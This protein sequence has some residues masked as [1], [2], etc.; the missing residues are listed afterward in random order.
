MSEQNAVCN[1]LRQVGFRELTVIDWIFEDEDAVA[2]IPIEFTQ[3]FQEAIAFL[4]EGAF[5]TT[6]RQSTRKLYLR[7]SQCLMLAW[8]GFSEHGQLAHG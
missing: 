2:G 4:A 1:A 8:K 6:L 5:Q 3:T 7:L